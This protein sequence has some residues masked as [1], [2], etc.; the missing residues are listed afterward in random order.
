MG[1]REVI[2][3]GHEGDQALTGVLWGVLGAAA[4]MLLPAAASAAPPAYCN[5]QTTATCLSGGR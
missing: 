4:A 2:A 5:G 1:E 3:G